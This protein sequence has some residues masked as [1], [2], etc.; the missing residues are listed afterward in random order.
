MLICESL[1]HSTRYKISLR[2][3]LYMYWFLLTTYHEHI[4]P[5][6]LSAD[7]SER[8]RVKQVNKQRGLAII[9]ER[10]CPQVITPGNGRRSVKGE[11]NFEGRT[12]RS[13]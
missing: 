1:R 8:E 5:V 10:T 13:G 3:S 11:R 6:C 7:D 12:N 4:I 2:K 9:Q